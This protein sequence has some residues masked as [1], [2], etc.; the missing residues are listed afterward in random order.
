[1]GL[2][3][4]KRLTILTQEPVSAGRW[5]RRAVWRREWYLSATQRPLGEADR[6][7]GPQVVQRNLLAGLSQIGC[8][9]RFNPPAFAVTPYVGVL[10]NVHALQWAVRAKH[11]GRIERLVAGPNLVVTPLE[12]DRILCAPE[13]DV[14]VTPANWVSQ[15]YVSLAP[16]LEGRVTE[17]PVG[18]DTD[19][20]RPSRTNRQNAEQ[21]HWLIYDKTRE[22]SKHILKYVEEILRRRQEPCE[23][24]SHGQYQH[25]EYRN[26]LQRSSAIVFLSNSESQGIALFEAWACDVPTLVYDRG[27]WEYEGLSFPASSAPYWHDACGKRFSGIDDFAASLEEFVTSRAQFAPRRYVVDHFALGISAAAYRDI[28]LGA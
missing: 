11:R 17:W 10:S 26:L 15:L 25:S 5:L 21:I 16:E 22:D 9:F 7:R 8:P 3:A 24:I 12:A 6:V 20:W 2:L 14:V 27:R 18:I 1:M 19:C 13:T 4:R 28:L 23:V